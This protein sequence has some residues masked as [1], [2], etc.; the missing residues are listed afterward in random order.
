MGF[1]ACRAPHTTTGDPPCDLWI[2]RW[3]LTFPRS[4]S[5]TEGG[6]MDAFH[7]T[8]KNIDVLVLITGYRT[9]EKLGK[10]CLKVCT[11]TFQVSNGWSAKAHLTKAHQRSNGQDDCCEQQSVYAL[12]SLIAFI[13]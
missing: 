2:T 12:V 4:S 13:V 11:N 6:T 3:D 7:F 1:I 9:N 8:S 10:V 5:L